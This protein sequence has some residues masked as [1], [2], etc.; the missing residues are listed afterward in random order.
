[1]NILIL[2]AGQVGYNC[3][4]IISPREEANEVTIVDA[5]AEQCCAICRTGSM[6][7]PSSATPL[8]PRYSN[9]PAPSEADMVIALTNSDEI[10]MV[11]CQVAY[12]MFKTPT[13]IA[14]IRAS[15]VHYVRKNSGNRARSPVDF[16][17]SPRNWSR[18]T[19]EQLI[20]YPGAFQVLEFA[21][22]RSAPRR[23]ARAPRRVARRAADQGA[24]GTHSRDRD[25]YRGDLPQRQQ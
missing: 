17:I 20:H 25:T 15:R 14:R 23:R 24:P 21:E 22:R 12:T 2:G 11:A 1:M 8:I 4:A 3:C 19:F 16:M 9:A 7:A 5:D 13:K 10:N 18:I 6:F